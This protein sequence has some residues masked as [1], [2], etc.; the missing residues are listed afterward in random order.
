LFEIGREPANLKPRSRAGL[1]GRRGPH[2]PERTSFVYKA[3]VLKTNSSIDTM[4][5]HEL[6]ISGGSAHFG[7]NDELWMTQTVAGTVHEYVYNNGGSYLVSP[8][9]GGVEMTQRGRLHYLLG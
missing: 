3:Y 9:S 8:L 1:A 4:S 5:I 6:P 2:K 7:T